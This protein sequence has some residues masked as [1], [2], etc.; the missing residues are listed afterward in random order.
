MGESVTVNLTIS[1]I[2]FIGM[3]L[4]FILAILNVVNARR[5]HLN[6]LKLIEY[7]KINENNARAL[8]DIMNEFAQGFRKARTS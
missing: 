6:H 3:M 2:N 5:N 4:M 8:G 1:I 7:A